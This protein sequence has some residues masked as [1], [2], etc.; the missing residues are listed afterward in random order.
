MDG[1]RYQFNPLQQLSYF[2]LIFIMAPMSML[3]GI[4]M[5]P[6][7]DNR[8]PVFPKLFGSRQGARS[9]H[10][11]LLIGYLCFLV[12]HA[13]LVVITGFV[14]NINHIVTGHDGAHLIGMN[15]RHDLIECFVVRPGSTG[16]EF[17]WRY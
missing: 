12:V 11:I 6:A 15:L 1:E 14:R 4:A 17:L 9:I 7:V 16:H 2:A 3:T 13:G 10:F 8:F 5:S